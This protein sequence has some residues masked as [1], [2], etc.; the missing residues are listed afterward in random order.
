[1]AL[2]SLLNASDLKD[3]RGA[4]NESLPDVCQISR[5]TPTTD[6]YG[7]QSFVYAV[8][9]TTRC[10]VAPSTYLPTEQ[11]NAGRLLALTRYVI[12]LPALT[13]V[14]EKDRLVIAGRTYEVISV[15]HR[16]N[17]EISRRVLC[18]TRL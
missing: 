18:E 15:L 8:F 9:A 12:T 13:D 6:P 11:E 2:E 14:T 4:L 7:S 17:M 10:R 1:M 5:L 3:M 16:E